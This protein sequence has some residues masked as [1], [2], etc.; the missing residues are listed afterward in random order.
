[1]TTT[2]TTT[3]QLVLDAEKAKEWR[4]FPIMQDWKKRQ[5]GRAITSIPWGVIA[6][7]EEQARRN[8]DQSLKRLAERGGLSPCEAIAVL[9]GRPLRQI[10]GSHTDDDLRKLI[11]LTL[12]FDVEQQ[13][14][15]QTYH[16]DAC[17]TKSGWMY[18]GRLWTDAQLPGAI[19]HSWW[20]GPM[21]NTGE[22]RAG[23]RV[24]LMPGPRDYGPDGEPNGP[25]PLA[26]ATLAALPR[27]EQAEITTGPTP[28][29]LGVCI[30]QGFVVK[31]EVRP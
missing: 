6:P 11:T 26:T 4:P 2:D 29:G 25:A 1:M 8:H 18:C 28:S 16:T 17:E 20:Q 27:V 3:G 24:W 12:T 21:E 13:P 31:A 30:V 22:P 14:E 10:D 7:H 5:D 19:L 9:L 15:R 23:Q